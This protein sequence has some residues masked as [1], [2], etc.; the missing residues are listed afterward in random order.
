M[1]A[2]SGMI[3][4][5]DSI[6]NKLDSLQRARIIPEDHLLSGTFS[7]PPGLF[8]KKWITLYAKQPNEIPFVKKMVLKLTYENG[9][10]ETVVLKLRDLLNSRSDWQKKNPEVL[11]AKKALQNTM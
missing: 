10:T 4:A 2:G 11:A 5:A 1:A 7:V 9:T 8:K 6:G 3:S